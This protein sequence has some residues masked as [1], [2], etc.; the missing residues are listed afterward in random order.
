M[1]IQIHSTIST[2]LRSIFTED[3]DNE[4]YY[5][6]TLNDYVS[7][8]NSSNNDIEHGSL[9]NIS[10]ISD[11]NN[12][13]T[14]SSTCDNSPKT[15]SSSSITSNNVVVVHF[16]Q[17]SKCSKIE[18]MLHEHQ[19]IT[20]DILTYISSKPT[21]ICEHLTRQQ[22]SRLLQ[23]YLQY[24]SPTIIHNLFME[25]INYL[26]LLFKDTYSNHFCLK[27]FSYLN[28]NDRITYINILS[29]HFN[30]LAL[31]KTSTH[32]VQCIIEQL[33]TLPEQQ[34]LLSAVSAEQ[35][36]ALALNVY[37]THVLGK[38]LK[39]FPKN[40]MQ[41][42]I[43]KLISN[44]ILLSTNANG[45]CTVKQLI[46]VVTDVNDVNF[47]I[48]KRS[49][50]DNAV[51]L[52]EDAYGNYVLQGALNVWDSDSVDELMKQLALW[53]MR[54]SLQKYSSNVIEKCIIE[55]KS[56]FLFAI[57][58]ILTNINM[59]NVMIHNVFGTFVIESIASVVLKSNER[60]VKLIGK[61]FF[62]GVYDSVRCFVK[63]EAL[64]MK[65]NKKIR[66]YTLHNK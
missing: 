8:C 38:M 2:V 16:P 45:L 40:I 43:T 49:I 13:L 34:A 32:P 19:S 56:F 7:C 36:L 39:H 46:A 9:R 30:D 37:G 51:M 23:Y 47:H 17:Q 53:F 57:N 15:S 25:L 10:T 31:N 44:V 14:I 1:S 24:T 50:I 58:T 4:L 61:K 62:K 22:T 33:T 35:A 63:D 64:L 52:C 60:Y 65:W 11:N 27:L 28:S 21:N 18:S 26:S 20:Q 66:F 12:N 42:I 3:D 55:H 6:C 41:R 54:L 48:M 29:Q 5:D 59:M